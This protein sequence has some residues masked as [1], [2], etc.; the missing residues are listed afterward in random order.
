MKI[1][2]IAQFP[3]PI[4]G[5]SKAVE[6]L[7]NSRLKEKYHFSKIDISNNKAFLKTVIRLLLSDADCFYLTVSQSRGGNLRDLLILLLLRIRQKKFGVHVHGGLNYRN[8][9]DH[10]MPAWQRLINVKLLRRAS[11]GIV[12]SVSLRP[13]FD[14]IIPSNHIHVIENGV[15]KDIV[16][17]RD[18]FSKILDQRQKERLTH[19]LFLSNMIESKGYRSVLE[20]AHIQ[21]KMMSTGKGQ[22]FVF[23]FAGAF[24][25]SRERDFFEAFINKNKLAETVI[26]HGIVTGNEKK[27]LLN[28]SSIFCLPT[29]YPV[30]GQPISILEALANG[31]YIISSTHAA[32]PD[33]ITSSQN[34]KLYNS[35]VSVVQ[36]YAD[37][38]NLNQDD[39]KN[40]AILNRK[41][42]INN[43]TEERYISRFEKVFDEVSQY[44]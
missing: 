43:Y 38:D 35:D 33:I 19:V 27:Q 23:D 36:M 16:P 28:Q 34:G 18:Q 32:I 13:N 40:A 25:D 26:Y 3:P 7:F 30:E 14:G 29:W 2:L 21:K 42:F 5:L 10:G 1:C 22:K 12:L 15:D 39:L 24:F 8:V 37:M 11:F 9:L 20:L 41:L 17:S 31:E 44:A 6:T 4:H